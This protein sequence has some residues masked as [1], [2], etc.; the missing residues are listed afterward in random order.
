ME[1]TLKGLD[2]DVDKSPLGKVTPEQ[3]QAGYKALSKI[4]DIIN[5][6]GR[7]KQ[8]LTDACNE[9]YTRIP[10]FFGMKVPPKITLMDEVKAKIDLL[11]ALNDICL[12]IKAMEVKKEDDLE[13][14]HPVDVQYERLEVK[15]EPLDRDSKDFELLE[16]YIL[17]THGATHSA[18]KMQVEDIFVCEKDSLPFKDKGN[19]MLLFHGSRLS[20]FAG[21]LSQGL[22]IAPPE[23]P[24]TGYMF[25]KGCYFAD[26]SSK[27]ANYCFA[28]PSKPCGLLLLC[29]VA[30]GKSNE[31]LQ[32]DYNANKLPKGTS[33]VKG[34]GRV[35]PENQVK[36]EDGTIVPLGPGVNKAVDGG[37]LIYNEFI[38]YDTKQVRLRYLAKI[39]FK[40][41]N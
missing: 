23:A 2:Y 26:M 10:H 40:F 19:R 36:L 18:Y 28:T 35:R 17:S 11:E 12:G 34:V 8:S 41:Q 20:N 5:N 6:E 4:A 13:V 24:V 15:L 39:A 7:G 30:L 31:L 27:S 1:Q 22:R 25:G 21:I 38:V 32:A 9:F 37:S 33:S 16:K 14:R 29:E 3:I